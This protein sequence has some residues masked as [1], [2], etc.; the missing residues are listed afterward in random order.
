[1]DLEHAYYNMDQCFCCHFEFFSIVRRKHVYCAAYH[2]LS[3][4]DL[5]KVVRAV[6]EELTIYFISN[7]PTG[8]GLVHLWD[9]L[10]YKTH[11]VFGTWLLSRLSGTHC[12]S[13]RGKKYTSQNPSIL[14]RLIHFLS[15]SFVQPKHNQQSFETANM[16][17]NVSVFPSILCHTC[18]WYPKAWVHQF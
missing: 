2:R 12:A 16:A 5:V 8:L 7:Q 9:S 4:H 3:K 18:G 11:H 10:I 14:I 17:T 13:H 15:F 1:M 6:P